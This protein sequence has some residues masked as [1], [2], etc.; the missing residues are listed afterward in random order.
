MEL[1]PPP[2]P[3]DTDE[4][5]TPRGPWSFLRESVSGGF[6]PSGL[7][8]IAGWLLAALP[9]AFFLA[10]HLVDLAGHSALA[11][12]WG[13]RLDTRELLELWWNSPWR[14]QPLP[15]WALLS[16][17]VG[18]ALSLWSGWKMQAEQLV[19][20][21]TFGPWFKG[22]L[23]A[24][25][26]GPLPLYLPLYVG[27]FLLK[28]F[29]ERGIDSFAWLL[30]LIRPLFWLAW[31]GAC[32]LQWSLLRVGRLEARSAG[33]LGHLRDSFL[34]LWL[35]PLQWGALI[36]GGALLRILLHGGALVLGWRMGGAALGRVW[37][38][39]GLQLVAHVVGAWSL[40]WLLRVAARFTAHDAHIR[41]ERA[42]LEAAVRAG[43]PL[44]A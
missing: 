20:Q 7:G 14:H 37:I 13:E 9:P 6:T 42:A 44:E 1:A 2:S 28:A 16:L 18:L 24:L 40:G 43:G 32:F 21:A 5:L 4:A 10:R 8:L 11:I 3:L 39:V 35:H 19:R 17:L 23:E 26:L 15:F 33:W 22:A 29:G 30:F 25:L 34:R 12:H 36:F 41:R 38:L 27:V 31:S